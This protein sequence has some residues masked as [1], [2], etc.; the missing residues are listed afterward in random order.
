LIDAVAAAAREGERAEI[1]IKVNQ[2]TD[3]TV[4]EELY[5]ASTAGARI[6]VVA[7]S[8]SMLRA[9]VPGLSDTI[10]VRSVLGRFLEHSR[11]FVF[12]AGEESHYL[13]GS[14]DLMPRNLDRRIEIV[15][16]VEQPR[17]RAELDA[18][19]DALLADNVN[20]WELHAD[21][22]WKR[23]EPGEGERPVTAQALLMRRAATRDAA[24]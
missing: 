9:G 3:P 15:A 19:F 20:A 2:L 10:R 4:I 7:R 6:D 17:A 5:R 12:H 14:A 21:D 11:V 13:I 8:I 22:T 16:P 1:R 24:A 23:I 18:V